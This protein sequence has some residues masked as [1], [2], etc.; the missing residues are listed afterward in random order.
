MLE[1]KAIKQQRN[2]AKI[3]ILSVSLR[4]KSALFSH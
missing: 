2:V 3:V 4:N 1:S